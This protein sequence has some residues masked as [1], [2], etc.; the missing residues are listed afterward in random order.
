[1]GPPVAKRFW[2][3]QLALWKTF[4]LFVA[5]DEVD[6]DAPT[7]PLLAWLLNPDSIEPLTA[8]TLARA[9]RQKPP[10][11]RRA[12]E[13][14]EITDEQRLESAERARKVAEAVEREILDQRD[15]ELVQA[16]FSENKA[17]TNLCPVPDPK[18]Q[19]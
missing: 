16:K 9:L 18:A 5:W 3:F 6:P 11:L 2:S 13:W 12:M 1:M 7:R 14:L 15:M 4:F 8:H 17:N 10:A 19:A